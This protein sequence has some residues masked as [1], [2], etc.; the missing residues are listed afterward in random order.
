[1]GL[2]VDRVGGGAVRIPVYLEAH[3]GGHTD[4]ATQA[5]LF[6]LDYWGRCGQGE[7]EASAVEALC[8]PIGL[9]T[10][11][12]EVV[13]R[14][15]GDEQ[16]FARDHVPATAAE[17]TATTAI[18][19]AVRA[20]TTDLIAQATA[21]ELDWDDP[22]RILPRWASWRTLRQMGWHIADTESR[23]Y[24]SALG[25]PAPPRETDLLGELRQSADHVLRTLEFLPPA[26]SVDE[27]G[28]Q[29]T[30]TKVLRRLAWHERAELGVMRD[31]LSKARTALNPEMGR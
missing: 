6:E 19:V 27:Q 7:D 17:L 20:E 26:L 1:M 22:E 9:S 29:W 30:T 2:G 10:A 8:R 23:Y 3:V 31:L 12:V 16:A 11:D 28:E 5:W 14:I 24:L 4:D 21:D 13:D 25:M 18:L 15:S